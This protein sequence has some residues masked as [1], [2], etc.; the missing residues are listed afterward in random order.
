MLDTQK[1]DRSIV[2]SC[3]FNYRKRREN[4]FHACFNKKRDFNFSIFNV[5]A[6]ISVATF[7]SRGNFKMLYKP[8]IRYMVMIPKMTDDNYSYVY[9]R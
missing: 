6:K 2:Q 1:T 8:A 7:F 9:I 5:R 4:C 3:C